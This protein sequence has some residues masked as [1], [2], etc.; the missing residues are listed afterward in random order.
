MLRS[1]GRVALRAGRAAWGTRAAANTTVVARS[2]AALEPGPLA[3]AVWWRGLA[4]KKAKGKKKDADVPVAAA[5]AAEEQVSASSESA[6]AEEEGEITDLD[7]GK[8]KD[9]TDRLLSIFNSELGKLRSGRPDPRMLDNVK[10]EAYGAM[11][12]L[13]D[14]ALTTMKGSKELVVTVFDSSLTS[15]VKEAIA[16]SGLNLNPGDIVDGSKLS[17]PIPK[18]TKESREANVKRAKE[19]REK[20]KQSLNAVRRDFMNVVNRQKQA[21]EISEDEAFDLSNEVET[22]IKAAQ[23]EATKLLEAREKELLEA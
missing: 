9:R 18:T 3:Q 21:K 14:V 22:A 19:L 10:V 11:T 6:K 4:K 23:D 20:T 12:P 5:A 1:S 15:S 7:L 8:I 16:S 2:A 17:V 13:V